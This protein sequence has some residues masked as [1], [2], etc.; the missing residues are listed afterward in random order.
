MNIETEMYGT[1]GRFD[2]SAA[3][4]GLAVGLTIHMVLSLVGLAVGAWSL[5]TRTADAS[6]ISLGAGIWNGLS[7]LLSSFVGS[8]VMARLATQAL[9]PVTVLHTLVLWG[10]AWTLFAVA[11][12]TTMA[13]LFG[14]LF[15]AFSAGFRPS[16]PG[17]TQAALDRAGS[18]AMWLCAMTILTFG[19]T[20][21]GVSR[22]RRIRGIET[23]ETSSRRVAI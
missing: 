16:N 10:L 6:G 1:E 13:A 19:T 15:S 5:D 18:A 21:L 2:W 23:V 9:R 17:V 8:Y 11:A 20:F 12:S 3:F 22:G 7:M 14:G 4:S